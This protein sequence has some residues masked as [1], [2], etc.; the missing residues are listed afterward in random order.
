MARQKSLRRTRDAFY[1]VEFAA[2]GLNMPTSSCAV[3]SENGPPRSGSSPLEPD[4]YWV[5]MVD[6]GYALV[7]SDELDPSS[8]SNLIDFD[9]ALARLDVPWD[10]VRA[11]LGVDH[12]GDLWRS[13]HRSPGVS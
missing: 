9:G 11:E 2:A 4:L 6:M 8:R 7:P 10:G 3:R 12:I 13:V 1:D 5:R